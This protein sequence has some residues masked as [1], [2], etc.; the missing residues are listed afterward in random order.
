MSVKKLLRNSPILLKLMKKFQHRLKKHLK[1]LIL[2]K[3]LIFK[4]KILK[5]KTAFKT[6]QHVLKEILENPLKILNEI[7]AF[8][9]KV[10]QVKKKKY[11]FF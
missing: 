2:N 8:L 6:W 10:L 3:S 9:K 1:I 11:F 7:H 5:G 4:D